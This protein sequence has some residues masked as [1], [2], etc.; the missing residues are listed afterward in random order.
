MSCYRLDDDLSGSTSIKGIF[1]QLYMSISVVILTYNSEA[2]VEA[3][4]ATASRVSDDI[5][6]VDSGSTDTTLSLA[7][8]Y[9]AEIYT[10]EF[11]NY[12]K[13]RNWAIDNL[14]FKH[15]WQLHLDSDE[16]LSDELIAEINNVKT[17]FSDEISG[18]HIVRV[19]HFMSCP[20]QHGGMFP[21]W[22]LRLFKGG[23]GRCENRL[24][25][26]YFFVKGNVGRL[27]FHFVEDNRISLGEWTYKHNIWAAAEA[28]E[29]LQPSQS[30]LVGKFGGS[31]I[32][33]RRALRGVYYKLPILIRPFL[34]FIYRYVF[35]FGFLD[36]R[37]GL[38]YTVL[39][40]FWYRFL[41]DAKILEHQLRSDKK[42]TE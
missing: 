9:G 36:G 4:L 19:V 37:A 27:K 31:P 5:H 39:H 8:S 35:R 1:L 29:V 41:V 6:V 28:Q 24:Y 22:H 26:Q 16:W 34:F 2:T 25:D 33:R 14:N 23:S 20:I 3:T 42:D 32:Q 30:E 17:S 40:G 10:H 18:Y 38:V 15:E 11:E 12:S 21:I 13:Q 7:Q